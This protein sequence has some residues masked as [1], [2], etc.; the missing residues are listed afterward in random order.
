MTERAAKLTRLPIMFLRKRPSLRSSTCLI[1]AGSLPADEPLLDESTRHA[2]ALFI[3]SHARSS[4]SL[5]ETS[6]PPTRT[7]WTVIAVDA[8]PPSPPPLCAWPCVECEWE[9]ERVK[10][11]RDGRM[12]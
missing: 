12:H 3:S 10:T 1:P 8:A 6:R 7:G 4:R 2:T 9:W 5:V 11:V